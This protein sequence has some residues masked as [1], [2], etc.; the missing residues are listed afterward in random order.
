VYVTSDIHTDFKDNMAWVERLPVYGPKT[1]LIVAGDVATSLVTIHNTL[2]MLK[3]RF[4]EVFYC[5]GNHDLW[6]VKGVDAAVERMEGGLNS[7]NKMLYILDLCRSIGV[8]VGPCTLGGGEHGDGCVPGLARAP[9]EG[10][11]EVGVVPLFSWYK[12]TFAHPP[13]TEA[14]PLSPMERNFDAACLWP[15]GVGAAGEPRFSLHPAIA[16]FMLALNDGTLSERQQHL[17]ST[18]GVEGAE[19]LPVVSFSHFIPQPRLYYGNP[20]LKAVMGCPELGR[21]VEALG[22]ATHIFGHSH[23]D[24]DRDLGGTRYVQAA[25]GYPNDRWRGDPLPLKV[26]PPE[27]PDEMFYRQW[28]WTLERV[29]QAKFPTAMEAK[30]PLPKANSF[31]QTLGALP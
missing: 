2:L 26:W 18:L 22:S 23:L 28:Q 9:V 4:Q 6:V 31:G 24:V 8:R 30:A 19:A 3:K 14:P 21:Q 11:A 12:S 1:A 7:V 16:D 29:A 20:R 5:P 10:G 17:M 25:L 27:E 13:G 15:E